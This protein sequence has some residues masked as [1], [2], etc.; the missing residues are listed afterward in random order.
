MIAGLVVSGFGL[1]SVYASPLATMLIADYGL[2]N[3]VMMLGIA[4]LVVVVILAQ[5]LTPPPKGYVP[6]PGRRWAAQGTGRG[7]PS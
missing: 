5:L 3:A 1:A 4:F 7:G 6:G 2:Q